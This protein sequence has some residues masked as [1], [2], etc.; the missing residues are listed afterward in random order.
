MENQSLIKK[1][2]L[3]KANPTIEEYIASKNNEDWAQAN[4]LYTGKLVH[5]LLRN[6]L[7]VKHLYPK[8]VEFLFSE[9]KEPIIKKYL[10]TCAKNA[11]NI[12]HETCDSLIHSL[13]NYF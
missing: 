1:P 3:A 11:T 2:I 10:D 8:F 12:L 9:L 6:N 4:E 13:G 5:F 7:S